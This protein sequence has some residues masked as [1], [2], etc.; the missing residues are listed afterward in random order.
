MFSASFRDAGAISYTPSNRELQENLDYLRTHH[1][2]RD[3]FLERRI[4]LES[5]RRRRRRRRGRYAKMKK[6]TAEEVDKLFPKKLYAEWLRAGDDD[7]MS[8]DVLS[9]RVDVVHEESS[10]TP[11]RIIVPVT[12]SKQTDPETLSDFAVVE[13]HE[14]HDLRPRPLSNDNQGDAVSLAVL[15]GGK[16]EL[17]FDSGSCAICLE[18]FEDEDTVRGLVCGHVF[19]AE[20]VDP[21]LTRRRACC[22]ICKRDYYK[23]ETLD[24]SNEQ[25]REGTVGDTEEGAADAQTNGDTEEGAADAQTNGE[26][27]ERDNGN[28]GDGSGVPSRQPSGDATGAAGDIAGELNDDTT[29]RGN[30]VNRTG[31]AHRPRT[32]EDDSIDYDALRTDP[33]LQALLQEIIPISERVRVILEEHPELDLE[34]RAREIA[35][36]KYSSIWKKIFWKLMGI[37]KNDL[38]NWSVIQI[39]QAEQQTANTPENQSP[40]DPNADAPVAAD[41][42]NQSPSGP[43]ADE[44]VAAD[45]EIISQ[46]SESP[47]EIVPV[48]TS[49]LGENIVTDVQTTGA[50]GSRLAVA[51]GPHSPSI[52]RS[53]SHNP[54]V[55]EMTEVDVS[56]A[57]RRDIVE[58]QV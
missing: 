35:N 53:P 54:D 49:T 2:L 21:W 3:E 4:L 37:L 42:E 40:S 27:T 15:L 12:L 20:C 34:V 45:L 32:D 43:N 5:A 41:L 24:G 33:N 23:E 38:Y 58:R 51:T 55:T 8:E 19:H 29:D 57:L 47:N 50:S 18:T 48:I 31:T 10:S 28:E 26:A 36:T 39:Y 16:G 14:M 7:E 9:M 22:P 17:H 25:L 6:L 44:P 52:S 46:Q 11:G 30:A 13:M 1:F 56:D